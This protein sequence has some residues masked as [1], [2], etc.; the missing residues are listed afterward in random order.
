MS[1]METG[2]MFFGYTTPLEIEESFKDGKTIIS[3][4]LITE[5]KSR[6]N[7]Y[8]SMEELKNI[9][10]SAVGVPVRF[11]T[12]SGID[13]NTGL[14]EPNL[15]AKGIINEVGKIIKTAIDKVKRKVKF[16]AEINNSPTNPNI[17]ESVKQGW[18]ISIGG[19]AKGGNWII[20]QLGKLVLKIFGTKI[21]HV[22]LLSPA[23]KRGQDEAKVETVLKG[24]TSK[25][26]NRS[27]FSEA[28]F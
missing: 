6:N 21:N 16:W 10:D 15:H 26:N 24:A 22:Q 4:T 2:M 5:G 27:G 25:Y 19:N 14:F 12:E 11:G 23:I 1:E 20:D 3:G 28:N 17:A 18:G 7:M 9:A 8:Y 13:P